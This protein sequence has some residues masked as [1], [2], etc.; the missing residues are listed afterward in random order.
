MMDGRQSMAAERQTGEHSMKRRP[1]IYLAVSLVLFISSV[2][3]TM[4][5]T[6]NNP[7]AA[8]RRNQDLQAT[9]DF[10]QKATAAVDLQATVK[11]MVAQTQAAQPVPSQAPT[12]TRIPSATIPSEIPG[13][14]A[15]KLSYPSE[16]IPPLRIVAFRVEN[17]VKTKSYQYVEV[18]NQDTYQINDLKP[19]TYW[20]VAYRI[21]EAAQIA[22][23][24]EGGYTKAV[25]CGLSADCT[26]HA[27]VEVPVKPGEVTHNIDP[28]D[29]YAPSG[30]F[31]KDP[32]LP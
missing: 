4:S 27:L 16:G 24:L 17:G 22:P 20:I 26:D 18:F 12:S 7:P 30:S 19:G 14:I 29:W 8:T 31:P 15:G 13:S 10:L 2:M 23:G 21:S 9:I 3:C 11:V 32:T 25:A 28:D 1:A 6:A 5:G